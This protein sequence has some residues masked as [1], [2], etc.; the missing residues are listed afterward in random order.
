MS[1]QHLPSW[2][3][4]PVFKGMLTLSFIIHHYIWDV[5][6]Y[7]FLLGCD[8]HFLFHEKCGISHPRAGFGMWST[9]LTCDS[10]DFKN[11]SKESVRIAED[12]GSIPGLGRIPG[13]RNGNPLQY[14]CLGNS[15]DTGA[16]WAAV[17][18]ATKSQTQLKRL[19]LSLSPCSRPVTIVISKMITFKNMFKVYNIIH[20]YSDT[21]LC[22]FLIRKVSKIKF[23]E[24]LYFLSSLKMS[25]LGE[26]LY[27]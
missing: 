7:W 12:P 26:C 23:H 22:S 8:P 3:M 25:W 4:R 24:V 21:W 6:V 11:H 10:S 5:W 20:T 27:W 18:R 19:T 13:E 1:L 9:L 2:R 17:H 14:S 16:W 15:V